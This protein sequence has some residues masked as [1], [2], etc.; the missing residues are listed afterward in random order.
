[1]RAHVVGLEIAP[2]GAILP[3]PA[4]AIG[5][6]E[7]P[8]QLADGLGGIVLAFAVGVAITDL[9]AP[10]VDEVQ[11]RGP[12]GEFLGQFL[13]SD[14]LGDTVGT[15]V[16]VEVAA[17]LGQTL[18]AAFDAVALEEVVDA[19]ERGGEVAVGVGDAFLAEE[20]F[21]DGVGGLPLLV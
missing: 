6:G 17:E 7:L 13:D 8:A 19:S 11:E 21:L 4:D 15:G 1:M 20:E 2:F 3:G 18:F 12:G 14:F 16:F 5:V 10:L 9:A